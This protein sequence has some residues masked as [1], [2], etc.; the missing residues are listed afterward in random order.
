MKYTVDMGS[1]GMIYIPSFMM[2]GSDIQVILRFCLSNLGG[3][4]VYFTDGR[5]LRTT[6]LRWPQV[7]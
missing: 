6:P 3:C 4:N 7:A 2:I 1:G 5:D